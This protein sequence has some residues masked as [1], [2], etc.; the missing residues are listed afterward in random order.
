M[1][2]KYSAGGS[3]MS[4]QG[5]S[6][7][8]QSWEQVQ[9]YGS[10]VIGGLFYKHFFSLAPDVM[11]LYPP[12]VRRK[13]REWSMDEDDNDDDDS[14]LESP[15]LRKL[16]GKI[17]NAVGCTVA[18]LHDMSKL[19][20]L[21]TKLGA[22]H[23]AYGANECHFPVL[24]KALDRVLRDLL[25]QAFTAEV[26]QSWTMVYGFMSA[27]MVMGYR[28]A[29]DE[30]NRNHPSQVSECD[31]ASLEAAPLQRDLG[32]PESGASTRAEQEWN[33][34]DTAEKGRHAMRSQNP[35]MRAA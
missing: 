33:E 20:P 8:E 6:V 16:F 34:T 24:G 13:Y 32:T 7:V 22:R 31:G 1:P 14:L 19:V 17:V 12:E 5:M 2:A 10:F 28:Q 18:G 30:F 11:D 27:I 35:G 21:L 3:L 25:G 9:S 4:M 29:A 15:A 23:F 26:Q